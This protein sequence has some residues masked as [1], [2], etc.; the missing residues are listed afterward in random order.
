[1]EQR[2]LVSLPAICYKWSPILEKCPLNGLQLL[3]SLTIFKYC[4][5]WLRCGFNC[6]STADKIT[7]EDKIS[8]HKRQTK[9]PFV[10]CLICQILRPC[11]KGMIWTP[12]DVQLPNFI[13][14]HKFP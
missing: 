14:D 13:E 7:A 1:M 12:F 2:P 5:N 11:Q 10:S 9:L 3:M 6:V 8:G 4:Q